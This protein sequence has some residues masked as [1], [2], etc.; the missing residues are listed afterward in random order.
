M[1]CRASGGV[2]DVEE[3][4][5]LTGKQRDVTEALGMR[6]STLAMTDGAAPVSDRGAWHHPQRGGA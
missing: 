1:S 4:Q 3:A 5:G 2:V 6:S